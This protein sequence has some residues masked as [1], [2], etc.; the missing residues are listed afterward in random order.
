MTVIDS[1]RPLSG[2]AMTFPAR[3]RLAA[4]STPGEIA[5]Q[6]LERRVAEQRATPRPAAPCPRHVVAAGRDARADLGALLGVGCLARLT[7]WR[8]RAAP[9]CDETG[10]PLHWLETPMPGADA[11]PCG[12]CDALAL[13]SA[14]LA[15]LDDPAVLL[16][17]AGAIVEANA[18]YQ[19]DSRRFR[20]I[21][22]A[23][24][25]GESSRAEPGAVAARL[26]YDAA[27]GGVANV[28]PLR[29]AQGGDCGAL[30]LL[31]APNR[32]LRCCAPRLLEQAF[33][34]TPAEARLACALMR[35]KSLSAA[36]QEL[37][38]KDKT[39]RTYLDRIFQKTGAKSQ[40][41]L[42]AILMELY[43]LSR[44]GP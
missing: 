14:A 43:L 21:L 13:A 28:F 25:P 3:Q 2:T 6:A 1:R 44:I 34:L 36:N 8:A 38:L 42:Y 9:S 39:G 41:Q 23:I 16:D 29:D 32:T 20:Q 24:A 19:A 31:R 7:R 22:A 27:T 26:S 10:A 17:R 35:T 40:L 30:V 18:A 11:A 37:G 12:D 15:F 5:R 4:V 33:G